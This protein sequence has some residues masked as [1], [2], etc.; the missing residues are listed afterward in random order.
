MFVDSVGMS[1]E[2]QLENDPHPREVMAQYENSVA[3]TYTG[4]HMPVQRVNEI[5]DASCELGG[6][7]KEGTRVC[8]EVM[9]MGGKEEAQAA[10]NNVEG[11]MNPYL[12]GQLCVE[13]IL[14]N[15]Q[16]KMPPATA[17]LEG[18]KSGE[19]LVLA[20]CSLNPMHG[21]QQQCGHLDIST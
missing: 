1:S 14:A 3:C 21:G 2:W 15:M 10:S 18:H 16:V 20:I 8:M 11:S 19:K 6:A 7:L 13:K 17:I 12:V 5:M 4:D 9:S